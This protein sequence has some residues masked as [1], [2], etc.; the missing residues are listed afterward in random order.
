MS[1]GPKNYAYITESGKS[2]CKV[3]GLTLNCR[4]STIVSP[5]ALEKMSKEEIDIINVNYSKYIHRTRQH[6][7]QTHPLIKQYRIV[8]DKRQR[9][10]EYRTLPYGFLL[11][12]I[13]LLNDPVYY[14]DLFFTFFRVLYQ[15]N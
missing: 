1:G 10:S 3:K 8:Y 7:V 9:V 11:F 2:V 12:V 6:T 13:R 5:E 4:T 14:I 15:I